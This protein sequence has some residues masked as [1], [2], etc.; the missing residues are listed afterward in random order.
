MT[1]GNFFLTYFLTGGIFVARI[2][3][4]HNSYDTEL[5]LWGRTWSYAN[6]KEQFPKNIISIGLTFIAVWLWLLTLLY[7]IANKPERR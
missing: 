5:H 2:M 7:M 3:G 6:F 1:L 4:T